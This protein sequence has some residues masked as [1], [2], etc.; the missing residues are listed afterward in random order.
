MLQ[1][2]IPKL[3]DSEIACK[4]CI[5][6]RFIEDMAGECRRMPPVP[7]IVVIDKKIMIESHCPDTDAD[8]SCGEFYHVKG[9]N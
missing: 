7:L 9:F 1:T 3:D 5:F 4:N 6:W 8:F 2:P